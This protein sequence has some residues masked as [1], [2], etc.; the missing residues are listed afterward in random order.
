MV[1][2]RCHA[3]VV[4]EKTHVQARRRGTGCRLARYRTLVGFSGW[5][6]FLRQKNCSKSTP[7]N[8]NHVQEQKVL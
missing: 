3:A 2:Y 1:R 4:G 5:L 7:K 8:K 6:I